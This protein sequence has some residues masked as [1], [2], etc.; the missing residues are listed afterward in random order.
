[1][2]LHDNMDRNGCIPLGDEWD[3][4]NTDEIICPYCGYVYSDSWEMGNHTDEIEE[5]VQCFI[6]F[7]WSSEVSV[8]YDSYKID[9]VTEWIQYNKRKISHRESTL[10]WFN[11]R[12]AEFERDYAELDVKCINLLRR[13]I[14]ISN[15][16]TGPNKP[17]P[18]SSY[19]NRLDSEQIDLINEL[20]AATLDRADKAVQI[21]KL[22]AKY[23]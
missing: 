16:L 23:K 14:H 21:E 5:C 9:W 3:H 17:T 6:K 4:E 19:Y 7:K 13:V 18:T 10:R 22:V 2:N 15:I 1:M 20:H 8:T 11:E 12:F